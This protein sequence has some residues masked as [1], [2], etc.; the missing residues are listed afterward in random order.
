MNRKI[1]YCALLCFVLLGFGCQ[2]NEAPLAPT[3]E[4][5]KPKDPEKPNP[6]AKA[7]MIPALIKGKS[8]QIEF[9]YE[10]E[11]NRLIAL[12]ETDGLATTFT[13]KA[14]GMPSESESY[15]QN[16]LQSAA[17]YMVNIDHQ[18]YKIVLYD[19]RMAYIGNYSITYDLGNRI[20]EIK[21]Y[22]PKNKLIEEE[23]I[24]YDVLGNASTIVST[25]NGKAATMQVTYDDRSGIYHKIPYIQL[26][27]LPLQNSRVNLSKNNPVGIAYPSGDQVNSTYAYEYN[28]SGYPANLEIKQGATLEA[29]KMTYKTIKPVN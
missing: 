3:K 28:S 17:E 11:T 5:E 2:K 27:L 12:N 6:P 22:D 10:G 1:V 15:K 19:S 8:I 24:S 18:I 23:I 21:K 20:T 29:L 14:D 7:T 25:K 16:K 4:K 13:Y 9:K 26:L